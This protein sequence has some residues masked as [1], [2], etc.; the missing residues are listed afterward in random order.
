[1][2]G[3]NGGLIGVR[4]ATS[5]GIA[6]GLWLPN[7]QAA[8]RRENTWPQFNDQYLSQVRLLL[9]MEG[10]D[11]G[12]VFTDSSALS[13]TITRIG[14]PVTSIANKKFGNS[15][16]FGNT[17]SCL[18]WAGDTFAGD[19]TCEMFLNPSSLSGLCGFLGCTDGNRQMRLDPGLFVYYDGVVLCGQTPSNGAP[20]IGTWY[21]FA[22]SREGTTS[23]VFWDGVLQST[24][25]GFSPAVFL[26]RVGA[27]YQGGDRWPGYIDSARFTAACRYTSSFTPPSGEFPG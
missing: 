22:W 18:G 14:S 20:V 12:T 16:Y 3:F 23:R 11:N 4:R 1:M 6:T 25:S 17:S 26:N 15:S 8:A 24:V 5:T 2:L 13:Q 9:K 19:F 7:E 27:A 21:H 10:A